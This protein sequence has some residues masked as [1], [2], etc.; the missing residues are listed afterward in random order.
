MLKNKYIIAILSFYIFWIGVLP[1]V[2][3]K[4][5][6]ILCENYS[7]NSSYQIKLDKP[8]FVLSP[9]P[10]L[11]FKAK[12]VYLKSKNDSY[13]IV[14]E[15]PKIN[16]RLLP[17]LS[18]KLHINNFTTRTL[19][20]RYNLKE[21]FVLDKD[22]FIKID[23]MPF[24]LD[25]VKIDNFGFEFYRPDIKLPVTYEGENFVYQRKN[26]YIELKTSSVFKLA[27]NVSKMDINLFLPKNN[28]LKKTVFDIEFSNFDLAPLQIYLK[29]Y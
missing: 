28:D 1:L 24:V 29:H 10:I 13:N 11:T 14:L 16:I 5:A 15:N 17:L 3:T 27:D 2:L 26:R 6:G 22:F 23:A 4:V 21:R 19:K 12:E 20:S 7:H 18:G 9:L 8:K 25:S